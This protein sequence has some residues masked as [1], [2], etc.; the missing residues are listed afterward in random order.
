VGGIEEVQIAV[1]ETSKIITYAD[2]QVIRVLLTFNNTLYI[3][4][5]YEK[6]SLCNLYMFRI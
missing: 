6:V 5:K 2:F 4:T 1:K 3:S